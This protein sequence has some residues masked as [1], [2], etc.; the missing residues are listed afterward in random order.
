[1]LCSCQDGLGLNWA[2]SQ[3][4][5][6]WLLVMGRRWSLG[7]TEVAFFLKKEFQ[8]SI[9]ISIP[10]G[11]DLIRGLLRFPALQAKSLGVLCL[12]SCARHAQ[13]ERRQNTHGPW[14]EITSVRHTKTLLSVSA[15]PESW[16]NRN[17]WPVGGLS[18][19][20]PPP[21]HCLYYC[22]IL[23]DSL[24]SRHLQCP[25]LSR[26]PRL[27]LQPDITTS[28]LHSRKTL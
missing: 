25:P 1:M 20:P 7:Q 18:P 10:S 22:H 6:S 8:I 3:K 12:F 16:E 9:N 23:S 17:H 19:Q 11:V 27:L 24:P 15:T 5:V 21:V 26:W 13:N 28:E 14:A 4:H 2:P